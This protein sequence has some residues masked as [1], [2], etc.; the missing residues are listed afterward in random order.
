MS[1]VATDPGGDER[2]NC[3]CTSQTP[4]TVTLRQKT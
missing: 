3:T 1:H 4:P 2:K